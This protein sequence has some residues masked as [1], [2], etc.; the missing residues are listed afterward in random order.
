MHHDL[1]R[2]IQRQAIAAERKGIRQKAETV[3]EALGY[4]HR[5]CDE[6]RFFYQ[7][8][9]MA[10]TYNTHF[11]LED[12][13]PDIPWGTAVLYQDQVVYRD[14]YG[15]VATYVPGIW[16]LKLDRLYANACRKERQA[17]RPA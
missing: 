7:D 3:A 10:I 13:D 6:T 9:D 8:L 1:E 11:G 2:R 14:R 17:L 12:P 16:E 5:D 4:G 15:I